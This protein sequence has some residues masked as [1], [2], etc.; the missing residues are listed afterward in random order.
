MASID[1]ERGPE[2]A[3][4]E[5]GPA[6]DAATRGPEQTEPSAPRPYRLWVVALVAGLAAGLLSWIGGE[7]VYGLFAPPAELVHSA[8]FARSPEL[9]REQTAALIRNATLAFGVLGAVLG[10]VLGA[11]GGGARRSAQAAAMAAALGLVLGT[12]TGV[13]LGLA[14]VP[15]AAG[16]L[17]MISESLGFAMLTHASIWGPLGAAAGLAFGIGLGGGRDVALRAAVGGLLGAVLG[18]IAYDLIGATIAPLAETGGPLSTTPATR[19]LARVAVSALAALGAAAAAPGPN[20]E[21]VG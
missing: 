17:V 16:D 14:V 3:P 4:G 7:G 6:P 12:A 10:I 21:R 20:R 13:G 9:A 8:N 18:T 1:P 5:A 2:A 11:A 15:I 19:L